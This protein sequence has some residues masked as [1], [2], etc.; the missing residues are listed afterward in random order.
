MRQETGSNHPQNIISISVRLLSNGDPFLIDDYLTQFADLD[1]SYIRV[2]ILTK[3]AILVPK[4]I[5]TGSSPLSELA[6]VGV[7]LGGDEE[8]VTIEDRDLV[9]IIAVPQSLIKELEL[10]F[11]GRYELM[12]SLLR[13]PVT[14]DAHILLDVFDG[15]STVKIYE[16]GWK[17]QFVDLYDTPSTA[18]VVYWMQRLSVVMNLKD[19]SLYIYRG[20]GALGRMMSNNLKNSL[21][22]NS[23]RSV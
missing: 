22:A 5:L 3:R 18:T 19:Y 9:A 21:Y 12:S 4:A 16:K 13:R 11:E 20:D 14:S 8:I 6:A 17:L 7:V 1:N 10:H 15:L 23:K 2:E